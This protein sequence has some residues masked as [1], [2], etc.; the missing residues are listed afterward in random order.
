MGS[1]PWARGLQ[2]QTKHTCRQTGALLWNSPL[3]PLRPHPRQAWS[4]EKMRNHLTIP[5]RQPVLF[6]RGSGAKSFWLGCGHLCVQCQ[7]FLDRHDGRPAATT[8]K[9]FA[10]EDLGGADKA[11]TLVPTCFLLVAPLPCPE[12]PA[13]GVKGRHARRSLH[14]GLASLVSVRAPEVTSLTRQASKSFW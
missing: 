4:K 14:Q 6:R 3:W 7:V 8:T 9:R 13:V 10:Y 12:C 2:L 1:K 11:E 5:R